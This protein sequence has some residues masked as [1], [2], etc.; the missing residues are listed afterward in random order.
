MKRHHA[1][2]ALSIALSA[3]LVPGSALASHG[4]MAPGPAL[5]LPDD[6]LSTAGITSVAEPRPR[7]AAASSEA[8]KGVPA[9]G[10]NQP[11]NNVASKTAKTSASEPAEKAAGKTTAETAK[12]TATGTATDTTAAETAKMRSLLNRNKWEARMHLPTSKQT[13]AYV[14]AERSPYIVCWPNFANTTGYTAYAVDFKADSQPRGTYLNIGNWWMDVSSLYKRYDSVTSDGEA[15]PGTAY[16]GFQVLEDGR[17]VAIMSVWKLFLV[18]EAGNRSTLE[19]RRTYPKNPTIADDF[20]GEGTGV[21]TLVDYDWQAGRTYR[22]LIEYGET[23]ADNC[24]ISFS[25]CDLTTGEWTKLIAYDLGYGNTYIASGGCFLENFLAEYAAEVRT[26]EWS[27]F[28]VKSLESGAWVTAK[29]AKMERQY[30]EWPG[31][32]NFGSDDS[33][34]WAITSGVPHL[35]DKPSANGQEF[36]VSKVAEGSP[37]ALPKN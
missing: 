20:E 30:E 7:Q 31:S 4:N 2:F 23:K 9:R 37:K 8:A 36:S 28:K 6:G 18:D 19:A 12:G 33:C 34:F 32:Y 11:A 10:A 25:V 15:F 27:N 14:A 17:K 35:C 21:K 16:A 3:C 13:R 22:A 26:A 29:S 1:A 5:A 24:E